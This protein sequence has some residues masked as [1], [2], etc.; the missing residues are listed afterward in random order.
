MVFLPGDFIVLGILGILIIVLRQFD[1]NNRSLEK[2]RHYADKVRA[3]LD[4]I[5]QEKRE[6]IKDLSIDID[7]QE[8]TD[9]EILKRVDAAREEING[10]AENIE[11]IN[12]KVILYNERVDELVSLT[13]RVDENLLKIKNESDYVDTVGKRISESL[14]KIQLLEKAMGALQDEF[15]KQNKINLDNFQNELLSTSEE[16]IKVV[17]AKVT[18]SDS[19]VSSFQI[20]VDDLDTKHNSISEEKLALFVNE[21]EKVKNSY[22]D[23]LAEIAE[24][25]VKL[26]AEVF[27]ELNDSI[28]STADRIED[29]WKNGLN[30]LKD[31][32]STSVDA[33][34]DRITSVEESVQ[35]VEGDTEKNISHIRTLLDENMEEVK[36]NTDN[37]ISATNGVI[38]S[39]ERQL[40]DRFTNINHMIEL[41][42]N[43]VT[44][45]SDKIKDGI[46]QVGKEAKELSED[47]FARTNS[48][49]ENHERE[50]QQ[51]LSLISGRFNDHE[52]LM[53][54]HASEVLDRCKMLIN[55]HEQDSTALLEKIRNNMSEVTTFSQEIENQMTLFKSDIDKETEGLTE[56]LNLVSDRMSQ[57]IDAKAVELETGLIKSVEDKVGEYEQSVSRRFDKLDGFMEDLDNLE[58]N[59]KISLKEA[60]AS[61]ER[62]FEI[63]NENLS[64][65]RAAFKKSLGEDSD[66]I[67]FQMNELEKGLEVLKSQAYE[68]V[69]EKL[70]VFED[71]FFSD[72]K[73]RGAAME[74]NLGEWQKNIDFKM[75]EIELKGSRERDEMQQFCSADMKVKL[76][77]LQSGVYQQF[78]QFK[79]Q[80]QDFRDNINNSINTSENDVREFHVAIRNDV[81]NLKENS[82]VYFEEQFTGFKSSISERFDKADKT[83][84]IKFDEIVS[85]LD[86]SRKELN[87]NMERSQSDLANWQ[88]RIKQQL[89]EEELTVTEDIQA[90][91]TDITEN[92]SI[93]RDDFKNQR[94]ELIV[95]T[96]EERTNLKREIIENANRIDEL[97]KELERNSVQALDKFKSDY[98]DFIL[99]FQRK[100]HEFQNDSELHSKELRQGLVDTREKVD[101]LQKKMFGRIEEDYNLIT[102][103]L[104]EI[105]AKQQDFV[106]Q[107]QIFERADSLKESL[108]ADI[109]T[110]KNQI[111]QI[112]RS[113]SEAFKI[114]DEFTHIH[115]LNEDIQAKFAKVMSE[116]QKIDTMDERINK[117]ISLSDSVNLKLDEI[118]TT[119]DTLQDYQVRLRQIEDLQDSI[120]K[121]FARL[122]K[123]NVLIDTTTEGVDKNFEIL[124]TIE[125]AINT[126]R[127]ELAPIFE[128]LKEV[129]EQNSAFQ[130]EHEKIK[131]VIEKLSKIDETI[132]ELDRRIES[133]N[134]AREWVADTESRID[135]I[136]KK[137]REQVQLF[138]KLME[139]EGRTGERIRKQVAGSPDMEVR[140]MVLRL[141]HE[142]WKSEEIARTT[143]LSQGE[144]EL[145]LELSPKFTRK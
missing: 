51:R 112:E 22:N 20:T 24:K 8:K 36:S 131:A 50:A 119:H 138:G 27:T 95:S 96:N 111:S 84:D 114:Q 141:A 37:T 89:K 49:I 42:E 100:T 76:T 86:I 107:T 38:D 7:I 99:D 118:S 23:T 78:E 125:K 73:K 61:V 134:K 80:I 16:R 12:D 117:I 109:E 79:G 105:E 4:E 132:A 128:N 145:I 101:A 123:K 122:E 14:R 60:V 44:L 92:I 69:S 142:G 28:N 19:K 29:N 59:L 43:D 45:K 63:F 53:E 54:K 103:N 88:L 91:K 143:K 41:A 5:V 102:G 30:E 55:E 140:E 66:E 70:K 77:E 121:R 40:E 3:Q 9:K 115:H 48:L 137:A 133:M 126:V 72:L 104:K 11:L 2:V 21:M 90:F 46:F 6:A 82:A 71:E 135:T 98:D 64:E 34:K 52:E 144:V 17:E 15:V 124:G 62:D 106:S 56:K 18:E 97:D 127:G 93:I 81:D 139:K 25:G 120:D 1:K 116:K 58:G 33:I 68:N 129:K 75:D 110:L 13:G 35:I 39:F 74:H 10:H 57:N 136:G 108:G 47:V 87:S 130:T 67:K 32:V 26:E 65:E 94:E 85:D 31:S 83:I 113:S